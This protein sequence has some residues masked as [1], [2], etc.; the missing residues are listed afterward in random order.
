MTAV[1]VRWGNSG[2]KQAHREQAYD[3][4]NA[5]DGHLQATKDSGLEQDPSF[6]PA[7]G[8]DPAKT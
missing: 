6:H 5:T 2:H 8:T 7:E 4:K 1:L 3:V